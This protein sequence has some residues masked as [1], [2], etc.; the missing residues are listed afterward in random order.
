MGVLPIKLQFISKEERTMKKMF[1]FFGML[2]PMLFISHALAQSPFNYFLNID[3]I[4]GDSMAKPHGPGRADIDVLSF[5]IGVTQAGT[6]HL[7]G[8]AGAGKAQFADL[9][10]FKRIDRASVILNTTCATGQHLKQVIL[11][12]ALKGGNQQEIYRVTLTEVL[13][14][15]V[16]LSADHLGVLEEVTLSYSKIEWRY[17]GIGPDGKPS[18]SIPGGWDLKKN[19]R[20]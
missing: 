7:G 17:T 12:C 2:I 14:T 4:P 15:G 18:G 8:G 5:K 19:T 13:V 11:V 10:I 20:V 6:A 1:F 3:G 9:T 16:R